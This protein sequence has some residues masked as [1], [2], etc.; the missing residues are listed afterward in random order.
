LRRCGSPRAAWY[1]RASFHAASTASEPPEVKNTRSSPGGA[2][3]AIRAASSIERGCATVQFD[4]NGNSRICA[5]ATRPSSS[6]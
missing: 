6:P 3:S 5:C 2:S 4:V 1:W